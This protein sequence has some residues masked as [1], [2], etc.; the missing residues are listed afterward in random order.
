MEKYK[1]ILKLGLQESLFLQNT[2]GFDLF[3]ISSTIL[4][5]N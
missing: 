3:D 1:D 5:E 2:L 4:Y